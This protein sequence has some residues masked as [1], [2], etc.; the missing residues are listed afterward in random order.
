[1]AM[2]VIRLGLIG[3]G[4][5]GEGV[6][7]LVSDKKESL[8]ERIGMPVE[9]TRIAVRD[10]DKKRA[11]P[12]DK[13]ILTN[14]P[15]EI[16]NANDVDIVIE[17]MGGNE[18]ALA[19]S[20]KA[21]ENGKH[22]VTAN[23]HLL[24]LNGEKVFKA[25]EKNKTEIGFEAAVAGAVPI[26]H[27]LRGAFAADTVSSIHGIVNG[28]GNYIL[29]RMSDEGKPFDEILKDAQQL[30][31]AEADPT[32][33]VEG[34]DSA[35]KIAILA[36]L[37]FETPVDFSEIYTEGITSITPDDIAMA[38]EFGFRIKLLAIAKRV[39]GSIDV[40]VHPAMVPIDSPIAK[41]NGALNAVEV[42]AAFS[43]VNML[44]GPGAGAGPTASAVMG[45]VV[46]IARKMVGGDTGHTLPMN[47]P[48]KARK[49]I[50]IRSIDEIRSQ[51]YLRFTVPDEPGVLAKL[52]GA[53]GENG[54]SI[55]SMIQ[56]G[57]EAG[58]PVGVVMMT[59]TAKEADLNNAIRK[60][61]KLGVCSATTVTIKI[62][63][64][65]E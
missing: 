55:A 65:E 46:D 2:D 34:I 20:L 37:A 8:A 26:I 64:G 36:S 19:L 44:V 27:S 11:A 40:R 24:A 58:K 17:V 59:H 51:Y 39:N 41:V 9:I 48:L 50:A 47:V 61:E 49:K 53:L 25:V 21:I 43:G 42:T 30:G 22:I 33:D 56:R 3:C 60:I 35:H 13:N 15:F 23:K 10:I 32:F 63:D 6:A 7:R 16:V 1:M 31:Y 14:D 12:V 38:K 5:V 45:D 18:P 62:E 57:H 4:V 54:I 28:T 52:S 29:S